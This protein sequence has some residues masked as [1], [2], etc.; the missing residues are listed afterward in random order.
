MKSEVLYT[1]NAVSKS[2]FLPIGKYT[3][4]FYA[5]VEVHMKEWFILPAITFSWDCR[6]TLKLKDYMVYGIRLHIGLIC[7]SIG[8]GKFKLRNDRNNTI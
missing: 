5:D 8:I 4:L 1:E 6:D 7:V 3:L 2:W